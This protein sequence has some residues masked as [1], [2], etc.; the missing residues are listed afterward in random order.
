MDGP[1]GAPEKRNAGVKQAT[2]KYVLLSD[3]DLIWSND[4]LK[5]MIEGIEESS[6]DTAYSYGNWIQVPL[7]GCMEPPITTAQYVV[8]PSYEGLNLNERGGMDQMMVRRDCYREFDPA[9]KR[10]QTW[11]WGL[12]MKKA[13]YKGRNIGDFLYISFLVDKG[14]TTGTSQ[15]DS[16]AA[17]N[18]IRRKYGF[19]P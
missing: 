10:F 8:M 7:P 5:R 12:G 18:Y 13:G 15:E 2:S 17:V 19:I 11:D 4:S 3:D 1:G 16:T 6:P 14:I 9:L